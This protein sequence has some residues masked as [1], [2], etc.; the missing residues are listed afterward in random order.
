M[1]MAIVLIF[2]TSHAFSQ[3]ATK[4]SAA[5]SSSDI[6]VSSTQPGAGRK[7]WRDMLSIYGDK[8]SLYFTIETDEVDNSLGVADSAGHPK[9]SPLRKHFVLPPTS[10]SAD[11]FI[12]IV[13]SWLP[14]ADVFRDSLLPEVVHIR[15]KSLL[16]RAGYGLEKKIDM[17]FKGTIRELMDKLTTLSE[18]A[19]AQSN[20]SGGLVGVNFNYESLVELDLKDVSIRTVVTKAIPLWKNRVLWICEA[21]DEEGHIVAKVQPSPSGKPSSQPAT[22]TAHSP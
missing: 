8:F 13:Q 18:N 21:M 4:D 7:D 3:D 1:F 2:M 16:K 6:A 20:G 15:E 14:E 11:E 9:V 5:T 19:V 10:K 12:E 22:A 17:H